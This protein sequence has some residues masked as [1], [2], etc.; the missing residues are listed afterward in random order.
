L[1]GCPPPAPGRR[2]RPAGAGDGKAVRGPRHASRDGQAGHR[3]A[4]ADPRA[5]PGRGPARVGG[6]D[7][8][9]TTVPPPLGPP[10]RARTVGTAHASHA[11]RAHAQSLVTQKKANYILTVKINRPSLYAQLKSLPWR[12]VPAGFDAKNKGHGRAERRTLKV[13]AVAAGIAFP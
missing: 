1:A 7:N 2:E 4:A 9:N 10:A 8:G 3:P 6:K 5:S 13:T 11:Q 12:Q